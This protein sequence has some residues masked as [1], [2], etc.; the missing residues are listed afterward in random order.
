MYAI[1]AF[2]P[3]MLVIVLMVALN[4]PVRRAIPI[5]WLFCC[6]IAFVFWKMSFGSLMKQT[7][8]GFLESFTV[9]IVIFGAVLI[10][11]TLSESGAMDSIK[12]MF[13]GITTDA[14]VQAVI[15]GFLFGSFIEGAAGFGTPAALVG[16]L[17]ASIGFN[18]LAATAIALIYN[19]VP[20]PFGAVGTPTNAAI[21]VVADAV[22]K[23]GGSK[24]AF[25][26][27]LTFHT[28]LLMALGTLLVM[29]IV[30]V[31][32]VF[33]FADTPEKRKIKYVIEILPFLIYVTILFNVIYL[34]IARFLGP[35]LVSLGASAISM[36]I[37]LSTSR[38]GF[39]LPKDKWE[40]T[41]KVCTV[42]KQ[43]EHG[44]MDS[45]KPK[46]IVKLQDML[47]KHFEKEYEKLDREIDS[48]NQQKELQIRELL[49]DE[50]IEIQYLKRELD[51]YWKRQSLI[52]RLKRKDF[53]L[54]VP[55]LRAW[56]PYI[57]IGAVLA[58]TRVL[59]AL[60]PDSW[61]G[62]MKNIKLAVLSADGEVFWG[63]AFL[64][65]PGVIFILVALLS[66]FILRMRNVYVRKAWLKSLDQTRG[67]AIPLMF[68]VGIVYILRNSANV[69]VEVSYLMN[70][71]VAGLSSMLTMM[72]D[73]LGYLFKD[74]YLWVSP[75]IGVIGS[76][77]S[78]SNTVS[79]TLFAGLQFETAVLVGLPQVV[80]LALQNTGGA[81][82]N[83][84]CVNNVVSACAT[85]GMSGNEGRIIRLNIIPCVLFWILLSCCALFVCEAF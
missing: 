7:V 16:P 23:G 53:L 80:V 35:E 3:I 84:I 40:F 78:G 28:A 5:S 21:A 25:S 30:A 41:Q 85:T 47:E 77:I 57:I 63:F 59:S 50:D 2:V 69:S 36:I 75:L 56:V 37:V 55:I 31:I 76:F 51:D 18:P 27:N 81:I 14:R 19:S 33:V 72:A 65:N 83:M 58:L 39:L 38:K 4:M 68:G 34:L 11:N 10:M 1:L 12:G 20:V 66:V 29:L 24:E 15:I 61:A 8:I 64:W 62:V 13:C 26:A 70:G 74:F 54:G 17:M 73:G 32:Q 79:N 22:T 49:K 67:A 43:D 6:V 60:R 42:Q 48:L 46:L 45:L 9:L 52:K 82:G 44:F 71:K